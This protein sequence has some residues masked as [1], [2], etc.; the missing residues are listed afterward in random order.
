[1]NSAGGR[2]ADAPALP[3]PR[4]QGDCIIFFGEQ[5]ARLERLAETSPR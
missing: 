3:P 2:G 5:A 4:V 1:M